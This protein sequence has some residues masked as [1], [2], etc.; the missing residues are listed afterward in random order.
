MEVI[1]NHLQ[2]GPDGHAAVYTKHQKG[3]GMELSW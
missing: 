3:I 2:P 1:V